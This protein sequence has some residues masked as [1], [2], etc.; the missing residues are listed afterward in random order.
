[1]PP[2][3][4]GATDMAWHFPSSSA[5]ERGIAAG[6]AILLGIDPVLVH[7]GLYDT[8]TGAYIGSVLGA[9]VATFHGTAGLAESAAKAATDIEQVVTAVQGVRAPTPI[10]ATPD[11]GGHGA[12][13]VDN[14][15]NGA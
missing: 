1:M 11:V 9:M 6:S 2:C 14:T 4:S 15:G 8:G 5:I 3:T 7:F 12:A 13:G 10:T